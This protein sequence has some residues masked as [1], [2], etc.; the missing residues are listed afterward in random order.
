MTIY[1]T[2][3]LHINHTNVLKYCSRPWQNVEEMNNGLVDRWNAR[4]RPDDEVYILGDVA[5]SRPEVIIPYLK[6]MM[7]TKYL[8]EG[9]HDRKNLKNDEFR[10]QFAWVRPMYELVV[11]DTPSQMIVL[12]HFAMRVWNKSHRG[13]WQLY[14]HS[15]ASLPDDPNSLSMDVGV[16]V[17]VCNYAPIS[18]HEIKAIMK[19]KTWKP[20]DHHKER[21][22]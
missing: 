16:D 14:G 4:V 20:V 11:P 19:N 17:P 2:S 6:R 5:L 13:S 8:I 1:F 21:A 9:N 10:S 12:C 15:H 7:G 18:Y 22:D 3:D